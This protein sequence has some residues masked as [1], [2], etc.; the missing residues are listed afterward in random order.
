MCSGTGSAMLVLHFS[1]DENGICV[2]SRCS[3][4]EMLECNESTYLFVSMWAALIDCDM[5]DE[6]IGMRSMHVGTDEWCACMRVRSAHVCSACVQQLTVYET[7]AAGMVRVG[8]VVMH[9]CTACAC[10][11]RCLQI[12]YKSATLCSVACVCMLLT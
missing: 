8:N 9:A 6:E 4:L 11:C 12:V 10:V 7:K 5:H 1:N 3:I 2:V